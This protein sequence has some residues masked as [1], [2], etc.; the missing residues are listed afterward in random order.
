[1]GFCYILLRIATAGKQSHS[2]WEP[3]NIR[4]VFTVPEL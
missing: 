3:M 2:M 4:D 1:M